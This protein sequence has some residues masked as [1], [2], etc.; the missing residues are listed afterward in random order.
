[1]HEIKSKIP[2]RPAQFNPIILTGKLYSGSKPTPSVYRGKAV[3]TKCILFPRLSGEC[4]DFPNS[5]L[6]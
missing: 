6:R 1:M 4:P 2:F 5:E 3:K